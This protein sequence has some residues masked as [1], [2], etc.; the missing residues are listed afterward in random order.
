[1]PAEASLV[2]GSWQ[3]SPRKIQHLFSHWD[4]ICLLFLLLHEALRTYINEV[5]VWSQRRGLAVP[6]IR[7]I[8]HQL[9]TA[10]DYKLSSMET[11]NL[12]MSRVSTT[13][14]N[15]FRWSWWTSVVRSC[16]CRAS[17]ETLVHTCSYSSPEV[18]PMSSGNEATDMVCGT[19]CCWAGFRGETF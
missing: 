18:L 12:K 19:H 4:D 1:M 10:L 8:A 15:Q 17:S 2:P 16:P 3:K 11:L 13:I 7:S 5:N 6:K 9:V 14:N